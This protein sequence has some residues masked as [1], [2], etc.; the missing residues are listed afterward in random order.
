MNVEYI[1]LYHFCTLLQELTISANSGLRLAPPTKNPS[2]SF[3]AMSSSAF[4]AV[5]LPPYNILT[6]LA[7]SDPT[8]LLTYDLILSCTSYA[9]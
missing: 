7:T 5:T 9:Y 1:W 6:E 2:T 3:K 8:Y 4:L